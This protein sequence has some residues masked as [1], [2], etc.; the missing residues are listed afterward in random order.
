MYG[1]CAYMWSICYGKCMVNITCIECL[2][3]CKTPQKHTEHDIHEK[4]I[5][6]SK[7]TESSASFT[8]PMVFKFFGTNIRH[9]LG[10]KRSLK[11]LLVEGR[12]KVGFWWLVDSLGQGEDCQAACVA[13]DCHLKKRKVGVWKKLK[14][15]K[16]NIQIIQKTRYPNHNHCC[17]LPG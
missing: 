14:I 11:E 13:E 8:S 6:F 4:K 10:S 15:G 12:F 1:I 17:S 3:Y 7:K 5:L 16:K 2:G 9:S